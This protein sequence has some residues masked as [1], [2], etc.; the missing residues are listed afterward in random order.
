[1]TRERVL[2]WDGCVN[3]RDLGGLPLAGGGQTCFDVVVRADSIRG[4]TERGWRDL[5]DYGVLSAIDLRA[6]DELAADEPS[7]EA[8]IPVAHAP[9]APSNLDWPAMRDGYLGLLESARPRF[10]RVIGLVAK[11]ETPVVVHCQGGRDRTGLVA[12]LLLA[13][14]GVDYETIAADHALSDENWAPY[15]DA[16]YAEAETQDERERR[17][18]ITAPAGRTMAEILED[19]E[20]R[21]GGVR[22]YLVGGGAAREDLN[23]VVLRLGG[24]SPDGQ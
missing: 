19:V 21:Y 10:V 14:A 13:L 5:V 3:V 22:R 24:D 1:L 8:P 12:A 16:F 7:I 15:L 18:R 11:A 17:R 23:R 20:R 2:S 4:L 6:P 9:L